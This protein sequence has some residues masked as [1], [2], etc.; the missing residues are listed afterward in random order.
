MRCSNVPSN[1]L[2]L[3][4]C[5]RTPLSLAGHSYVCIYKFCVRFIRYLCTH[6]FALASSN[7]DGKARR[8]L[9]PRVRICGRLASTYT[10]YTYAYVYIHM[11]ICLRFHLFIY[12]HIYLD[13]SRSN[14][15]ISIDRSIHAS[16]HPPI[17]P[18]ISLYNI[19]T[20]YNT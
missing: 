4:R 14:P 2:Q 8:P 19:Q 16:T 20:I 15:S 1:A 7:G 11:Y 12:L 5:L 18:P 3:Q 9:S 10:M 13:L 17:D 6:K